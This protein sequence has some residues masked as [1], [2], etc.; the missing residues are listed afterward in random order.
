MKNRQDET[1]CQDINKLCVKNRQD[2]TNSP[3]MEQTLYEE[4]TR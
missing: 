1:N 4:Q 3:D 2:E